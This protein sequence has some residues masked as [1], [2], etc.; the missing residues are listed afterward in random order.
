M[1]CV[2]G[3]SRRFTIFPHTKRKI[4]SEVPAE[5]SNLIALKEEEY[6]NIREQLHQANMVMPNFFFWRKKQHV[7][8]QSVSCALRS[9]H[10]KKCNTIHEDCIFNI[11]AFI[12]LL[13]MVE[14]YFPHYSN[15]T[16]YSISSKWKRENI[17]TFVRILLRKMTFIIVCTFHNQWATLDTLL[18]QCTY[19]S[20]YNVHTYCITLLRDT[21]KPLSL[22]ILKKYRNILDEHRLNQRVVLLFEYLDP[23]KYMFGPN[24][25]C[26]RFLLS[27]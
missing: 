25:N 18:V 26:F 6:P 15:I 9:I 7:F 4:E 17:N 22:H 23:W 5:P 10:C 16:C 3:E 14:A 27:H 19:L 20:F 12:A 8:T 21:Q 1:D 24:E 13:F 11:H 2:L